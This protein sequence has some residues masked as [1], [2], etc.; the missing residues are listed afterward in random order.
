MKTKVWSAF[1]QWVAMVPGDAPR[2]FPTWKE[3]Y[4]FA[5]TAT[6]VRNVLTDVFG[7]LE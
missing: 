2:W 5:Y 1:H 6:R 4:D 3:A 7:G